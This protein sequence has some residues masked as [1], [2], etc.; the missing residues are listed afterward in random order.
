MTHSAASRPVAADEEPTLDRLPDRFTLADTNPMTGVSYA[1]SRYRGLPPYAV[2][3][4]GVTQDAWDRLVRS[5]TV[6]LAFDLARTHSLVSMLAD[7]KARQRLVWD[8][9]VDV[10][11]D[12][13]D[14]CPECLGTSI[15]HDFDA[16]VTGVQDAPFLCSCS[17]VTTPRP[18]RLHLVPNDHARVAA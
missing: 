6:G 8:G 3:V 16:S 4:I 2:A 5:G 11:D 17:P 7:L 18:P 9:H 15:A 10:A 14:L 1:Q 13:G 12:I